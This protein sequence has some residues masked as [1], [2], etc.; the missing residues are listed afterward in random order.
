VT[1]LAITATGL[2]TVVVTGE[3]LLLAFVTACLAV[4]YHASPLASRPTGRHPP[5]WLVWLGVLGVAVLFATSVLL[6]PGIIGW[7][8]WLSLVSQALAI[9]AGLCVGEWLSRRRGQAHI[10][11]P[12]E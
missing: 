9:G 6:L 7:P 11:R 4:S 10:R 12:L 2:H 8:G 5:Y 1:A 3:L